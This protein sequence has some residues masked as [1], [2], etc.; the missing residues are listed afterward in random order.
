MGPPG[1]IPRNEVHSC[2][3]ERPSTTPSPARI[4]PSPLPPRGLLACHHNPA[5]FDEISDPT[6]TNTSPSGSHESQRTDAVTYETT[7]RAEMDRPGQT[8]TPHTPKAAFSHRAVCAHLCPSRNLSPPSPLGFL[9]RPPGKEPESLRRTGR[10]PASSLVPER[11][12]LLGRGFIQ[13]D[14]Q[15]ERCVSSQMIGRKNRGP[16]QGHLPDFTR[17]IPIA[18]QGLSAHPG[19]AP[20]RA[21]PILAAP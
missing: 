5:V 13:F 7:K 6:G 18:G 2:L 1:L 14:K 17:P 3:H 15:P 21:R 11:K 8:R 12:L 10:R 19:K 9:V 16:F 4:D 20:K